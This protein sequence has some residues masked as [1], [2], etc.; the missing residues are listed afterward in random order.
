MTH[1]VDHMTHMRVMLSDRLSRT[2]ESY[3]R[4]SSNRA[5]ARTLDYRYSRN[6]RECL[7]RAENTGSDPPG[8][9]LDLNKEA[10][11]KKV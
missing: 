1:A 7:Y 9:R 11:R 4:K 6:F 2:G 3:R 5:P 10:L 8:I